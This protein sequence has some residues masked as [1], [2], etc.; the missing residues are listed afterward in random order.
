MQANR[1][2]KDSVFTALFNN[3]EKALELYSALGGVTLPPDT[4][5][6]MTT[7]ENVLTMGKINDVSFEVNG[8]L[9]ILVEHQSTIGANLS[10]RFLLYVAKLLERKYQS[11]ALY[12]RKP[13]SIPF[14]EFYVLY[15]GTAP[16]PDKVTYKLSDLYE[17]P[18]GLS[19]EEKPL[20]ELIVKAFN[21]N[22]GKNPEI[23]NR[24]QNLSGY[25]QFIGK[26]YE[27]LKETGEPEKAIKLA[28]EYCQKHGIL[29]EFLEKHT[30]EVVDMILEEWNLED[31]IA[32]AREEGREEGREEADEKWKPIFAEQAAKIAQLEA[33]LQDKS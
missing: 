28:V 16:F 13:V 26:Y 24:S 22:E 11:T 31:A 29:K 17:N 4:P 30:G 25:S 10:L 6:L 14:P 18:Q 33:Q 19:K 32:Y 2:I 9:I 5:V 23:V 1:K 12:G 3:P 27:F 8:K 21:I 7:L 15:N 20:L